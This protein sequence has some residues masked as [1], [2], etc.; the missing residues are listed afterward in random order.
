MAANEKFYVHVKENC[1]FN[2][3]CII[4]NGWTSALSLLFPLYPPIRNPFVPC[5]KSSP[6]CGVFLQIGFSFIG[7]S[8]CLQSEVFHR[9]HLMMAV[10]RHHLMNSCSLAFYTLD[11]EKLKVHMLWMACLSNH[12]PNKQWNYVCH[13]QSDRMRSRGWW[14]AATSNDYF[15]Q[16]R[17]T[18]CGDYIIKWLA[19]RQCE[20]VTMCKKHE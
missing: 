20:E 12:E 16:L 2:L 15:R 9:A 3:L 4:A 11:Q 17:K 8:F 19:N 7:L 5:T 18:F 14:F 1:F 10:K 13:S 6:N